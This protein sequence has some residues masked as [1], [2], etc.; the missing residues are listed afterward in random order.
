MRLPSFKRARTVFGLTPVND[1]P[2]HGVGGGKVMS[3]GQKT[4][5]RTD[6]KT[7]ELGSGAIMREGL[8]PSDCREDSAISCQ[9]EAALA[10]FGADSSLCP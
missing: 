10:V 2:F 5:P 6:I 1:R 3:R 8:A 9:D 4:G 7:E